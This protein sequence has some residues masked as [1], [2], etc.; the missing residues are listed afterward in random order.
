VAKSTTKAKAMNSET[1]NSRPVANM[2]RNA[3]S[4]R[5]AFMCATAG[6]G[7]CIPGGRAMR[8]AASEK[9]TST[10]TARRR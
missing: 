4:R 1:E 5:I 7:E 3:S 10:T 9:S 8:A 6:G 2:T